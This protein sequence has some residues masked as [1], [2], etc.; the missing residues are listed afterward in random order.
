MGRGDRHHERIRAQQLV[1]RPEHD[2]PG[3]GHQRGHRQ[4]GVDQQDPAPDGAW[5]ERW[6]QEDSREHEFMMWPVPGGL[7][8]SNGGIREREGE[9][10]LGV[11]GTAS[12]SRGL[13]C[14][15]ALP[16]TWRAG[17]FAGAH[18]DS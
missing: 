5:L 9:G 14:Q 2:H 16:L 7:G 15:I 18:S 11:V 4:P 10:T 13:P 3:D 6:T 12:R 1:H 17:G 8:T